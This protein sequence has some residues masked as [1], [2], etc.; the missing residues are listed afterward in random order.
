MSDKITIHANYET[1]SLNISQGNIP[2]QAREDQGRFSPA[3]VLK[4]EFP[5]LPSMKGVKKCIFIL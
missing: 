2:L 3:P 4:I 1:P 5:D